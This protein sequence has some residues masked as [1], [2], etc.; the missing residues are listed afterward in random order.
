MVMD[1][2]D[3]MRHV[4]HFTKG[5]FSLLKAYQMHDIRHSLLVIITSENHR[6]QRQ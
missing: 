2:V 1:S 6:N 5:E 3:T 4:L